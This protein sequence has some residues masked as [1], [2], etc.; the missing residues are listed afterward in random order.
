MTAFEPAYSNASDL[1]PRIDLKRVAVFCDFDGT[2][3]DIAPT[4]DGI[5][6]PSGLAD[7]LNA[8]VA[9]TSGAFTLVSGRAVDD[10]SRFLPDYTG[11]IWGGHGAEARRGTARVDHRLAGSATIETLHRKATDLAGRHDL[12]V[13]EK[14]AGA[15]VH[16]RSDPSC[17]DA[18]HA[19]MAA[20]ADMSPDLELHASKMAWEVRPADASKA[21]VVRKV[22]TD[23]SDRIPLVLGDDTTDEEAMIAANALGG[24]GIRIGDGQT[25]ARFRLRDPSATRDLL[26]TLL[27]GA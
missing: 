6:V 15:V 27:E 14:P 11:D 24:F 22:M 10:V 18:V 19:G 12:I 9:A 25:V 21:H 3:V 1:T 8:L 4:P 16:F 17:N 5:D 13:E 23:I 26:T 2:L 20:L 7:L